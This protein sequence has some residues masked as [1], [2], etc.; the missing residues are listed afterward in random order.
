MELKGLNHH[1]KASSSQKEFFTMNNKEEKIVQLLVDGQITLSGNLFIPKNPKGMVVFAHG[2][3]SSRQS[4]RNK[5]VAQI[6]Q[7]AGIS[8]L[9]IDLLTEEEE[10]L[11]ALVAASTT[12]ENSQSY[13]FT[14]RKTRFSR[15][16]QFVQGTNKVIIITDYYLLETS[17]ATMASVALMV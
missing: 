11:V 3:G 6:L 12:S 13:C 7:D 14:W 9:L 5:Y 15:S 10:D 2:G 16:C 17:S 1:D 8:T 4:P